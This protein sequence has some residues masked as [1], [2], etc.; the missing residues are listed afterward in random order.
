MKVKVTL[1]GITAFLID[2]NTKG[3]KVGQRYEKM[4][5]RTCC[6]S[7]LIFD[8]AV[9]SESTVLG[10]IGGG[11]SVFNY[12]MEW[13]RVGMAACH[14]GTIERLLEQAIS[15]SQERNIG[16]QSIAKN[17]AVAHRIANIKVQLEA[18][19][20][21]TYKAAWNIDNHLPNSIDASITK[22]FVSEAITNTAM[23][24][25]Q[26]HGGNGYM[27][28]FEIERALRDAIGSTIYSGTSDIQRN[29]IAR[30]LGL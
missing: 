4:G 29:I 7:E 30:W 21:L 19:R 20:M 6:I 26:I 22:L 15:Y 2:K 16:K 18:S 11:A 24:T 25:L 3:F 27:T 13:E 14:V 10:G 28:A 9:V 1:V 12:S 5:L 23:E 17:Q 8:N